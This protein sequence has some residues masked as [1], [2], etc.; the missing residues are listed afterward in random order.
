VRQVVGDHQSGRWR[1][2]VAFVGHSC[3]GR[4]A[5]FAAEQLRAAGIAVALVVCLDVTL[6]PPVP[7]SVG[8]AINLR[9]TR[10]RLYPAMPLGPAAGAS[11]VI[12]N[13]DLDAPGSP[14]DPAWVCHPNITSRPRVR[15]YVVGRILEAV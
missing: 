1:G 15:E 4:S 3:G 7:A 11:P 8:R 12:E 6:P 9:R 14:I 10:R 5:L 13:I 2:P